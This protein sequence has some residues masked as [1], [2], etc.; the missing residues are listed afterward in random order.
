MTVTVYAASSSQI[1]S[2]YFQAAEK[3]GELFAQQQ[4]HCING[5]GKKGLMAAITDAVL[6]NGGEVTGII[7]EFM[8]Q[9]GW[10]HDS[11]TE[12]IVTQDMHT[13]KQLMAQK[14]DACI[15]LPGG[16]GTLEELLEVI[17]WK[18]LGLYT[19]PIII[20]NVKHYYDDLLK[21]LQKS[22]TEKFIHHQHSTIWLVAETPE[23]A[24]ELALQNSDW[25]ENPRSF[26]AL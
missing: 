2:V 17:T 3:L 26:A 22:E 5:A 13:R 15:A 19:K 21:M 25:H 24:V 7:P 14:S 1:D 6:K 10:C 16:V 11:L 8:L 12:R 9:E 4:I 18:Q 23:E 20:F